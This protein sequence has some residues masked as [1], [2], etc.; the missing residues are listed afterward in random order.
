MTKLDMSQTKDGFR[1][2]STPGLVVAGLSREAADAFTEA[3][4]RCSASGQ[5][6]RA[7]DLG[8]GL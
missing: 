5:V 2:V 6:N 3:D 1:M 7:I 8:S 4:E